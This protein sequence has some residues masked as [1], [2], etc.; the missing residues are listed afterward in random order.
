MVARSSGLSYA[1]MKTYLRHVRLDLDGV[2]MSFGKLRQRME[3]CI[4]YL[5]FTR[6]GGSVVRTDAFILT[7]WFRRE[8]RETLFC[9]VIR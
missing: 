8:R 2:M 7:V 3:Q 4:F 5:E 9:V 1:K 6:S